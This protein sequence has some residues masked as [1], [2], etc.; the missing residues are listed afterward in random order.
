MDLFSDWV[1]DTC[2]K[3]IAQWRAQFSDFALRVS[4][5]LPATHLN[6]PQLVDHIQAAL[7]THAIP[8]A[9]LGI[10]IVESSLIESN[11]VVLNN[12]EQLMAM[13]VPV[14]IDDFGTGYSSMNYLK[15][16]PVDCIKLDKSFCQGVPDNSRDVAICESLLAIAEQLGL[17][18]IVEGVETENKCCF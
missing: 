12:L 14:S 9:C 10:E 5:N 7:T 4:F 6:S 2:C 3:Q 16:F 18:A 8:A 1:L 17:R 15:H 11:T 13:G